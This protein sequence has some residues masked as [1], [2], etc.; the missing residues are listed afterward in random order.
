V[1]IP[2][3]VMA[4]AGMTAQGWRIFPG[5]GEGNF[6][7]SPLGILDVRQQTEAARV[8]A[9]SHGYRR[10]SSYGPT[11]TLTSVIQITHHRDRTWLSNAP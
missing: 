4:V 6:H 11:G 9:V 7:N 5:G 10:G 8:L 1:Q 2:L 3:E